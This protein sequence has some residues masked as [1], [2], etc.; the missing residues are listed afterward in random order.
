MG[1]FNTSGSIQRGIGGPNM[2]DMVN[3]EHSSLNKET[4]CRNSIGVTPSPQC[5]TG[6]PSP[7]AGSLATRRLRTSSDGK[8]LERK[9]PP[10]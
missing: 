6:K 3:L 9:I 5:F 8:G 4:T 1:K 10:S 7:R 2:I